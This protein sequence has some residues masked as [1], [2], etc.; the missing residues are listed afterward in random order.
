M[1]VVFPVMGG[2]QGQS[3]P[4]AL[5]KSDGYSVLRRSPILL[6]SR[7][8]RYGGTRPTIY[9]TGTALLGWP[10]TVRR[11]YLLARL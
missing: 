9:V 10:L 11:V 5:C 3:Q 6:Y 2:V 7:S 4:C 1:H 8:C